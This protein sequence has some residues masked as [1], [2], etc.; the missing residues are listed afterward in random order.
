[1]KLSLD[2]DKQI[3]FYE[4]DFYV[5]SNFSSFRVSVDGLVFDTVEYAYHWQKFAYP[6]TS[7]NAVTCKSIRTMIEKAN[8]SHMA[9]KIGQD[10]KEHRDPHWDEKKLGVMERLL[11]L[12]V[13]Q[14]SYVRKKLFDSQDKELVENSW[15]DSYWGWGEDRQ[16]QNTLGKLWMKVRAA[17][18]DEIAAEQAA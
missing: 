11:N 15:R 3:F 6:I 9:F 18:W 7:G 14:H 1:M 16:G 2:T 5:F 8:S 13:D 12:K 10:F 4:Q 17:R